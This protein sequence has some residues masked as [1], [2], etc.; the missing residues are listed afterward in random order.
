M[1][2]KLDEELPVPQPALLTDDAAEILAFAR[3]GLRSGLR[4]ALVTLVEIR[5][6]AARSLGAHMAVR[7]DGLF[8][9]FVSGGCVEAGVAA[10]A[11]EAI[12]AGCDRRLILGRGRRWILL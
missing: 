2:R 1:L 9:G 4:C 6:G 12:R 10:E 8:C 7:E 11:L 5:G 3:E